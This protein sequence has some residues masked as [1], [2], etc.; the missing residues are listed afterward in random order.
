LETSQTFS[1]CAFG[2]NAHGAGCALPGE[3]SM[4]MTAVTALFIILAV[5]NRA[6]EINYFII[7]YDYPKEAMV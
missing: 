1:S 3:Q 4:N 2:T 7:V 6:G 5:L